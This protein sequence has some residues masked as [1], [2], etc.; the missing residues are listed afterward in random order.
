MR[1]RM[2]FPTWK[3]ARSVTGVHEA[4]LFTVVKHG[5][6]AGLEWHE[7]KVVW[8]EGPTGPGTLVVRAQLRDSRKPMTWQQAHVLAGDGAIDL[9]RLLLR[10]TDLAMRGL[11]TWRQS[12]VASHPIVGECLWMPFALTAPDAVLCSARLESAG[13]QL[14]R[15]LAVLLAQSVPFVPPASEVTKTFG[16]QT[17]HRIEVDPSVE[18]ESVAPSP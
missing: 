10:Q 12:E 2:I 13:Y 16:F 17:P 14:G 11:A 1:L 6:I 3:N 8:G 18:D 9:G 4:Q 5:L 7:G 15:E